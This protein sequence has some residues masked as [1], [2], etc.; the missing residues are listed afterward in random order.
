[1]L[2]CGLVRTNTGFDHIRSH[3]LDFSD[4]LLWIIVYIPYLF[5]NHIRF[6][7]YCK[8]YKLL[9]NQIASNVD[10]SN[11]VKWEWGFTV[12]SSWLCKL[13]AHLRLLDLDCLGPVMGP[14]MCINFD[15]VLSFWHCWLSVINASILKMDIATFYHITLCNKVTWSILVFLNIYILNKHKLIYNSNT[16]NGSKVLRPV[17]YFV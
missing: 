5:I 3:Q 8:P 16:S 10:Q 15:F 2:C 9:S 17:A 14:V 1:M 7:L 13:K 11:C 4:F 12:G 6:T